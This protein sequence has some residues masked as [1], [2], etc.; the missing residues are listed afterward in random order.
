M[1]LFVTQIHPCQRRF[2]INNDIFLSIINCPKYHKH[3]NNDA[4]WKK[5]YHYILSW[6][7]EYLIQRSKFEN[8]PALLPLYPNTNR[9]D[10]YPKMWWIFTTLNVS[11]PPC[12]DHYNPPPLP[13]ILPY[14]HSLPLA[15]P[16]CSTGCLGALLKVTKYNW[17]WYSASYHFYTKIK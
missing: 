1:T 3:P 11:L 6:F 12:T 17:K 2:S 4:N 9:I 14:P 15:Q 13:F 5:V 10:L 8:V 7:D 16:F